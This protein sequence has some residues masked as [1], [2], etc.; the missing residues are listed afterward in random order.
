[1]TLDELFAIL[2]CYVEEYHFGI[3]SDPWHWKNYKY[4]TNGTSTNI[5]T[6][7]DSKISTITA[8]TDYATNTSLYADGGVQLESHH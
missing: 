3:S 8:K 7:P 5:S 4:T 1:M 2:D 6:I